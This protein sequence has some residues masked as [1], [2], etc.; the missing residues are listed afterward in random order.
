MGKNNLERLI[1]FLKAIPG[2]PN[3]IKFQIG[4]RKNN[5]KTNKQKILGHWM[6]HL[7]HLWVYWW[8]YFTEVSRSQFL[9]LFLF[10]LCLHLHFQWG[11]KSTK[12]TNFVFS[13]INFM[14]ILPTLLQLPPQLRSRIL[15]SMN[16]VHR[17]H[18][19]STWYFDLLSHTSHMSTSK[20]S[21][22]YKISIYKLFAQHMK[23]KKR[24]PTPRITGNL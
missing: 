2:L 7:F 18:F 10:S 22:F 12:Y 6:L 9:W 4:L 20:Q 14:N 5:N 23:K 1:T 11:V 3:K 8:E 13:L 24:L 17:A 15:S 16:K 21:M 19:Q